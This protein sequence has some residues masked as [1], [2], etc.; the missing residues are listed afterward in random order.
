MKPRS[1]R[2]SNGSEG[3]WF[4]GRFCHRCVKDSEGKP[5]SILGRTFTYNETDK[6]YPKEW[7]EDADGPRCTAF[8][9]HKTPPLSIIRDP[10]QEILI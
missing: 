4:L 6:R 2:P 10:R 8:S 5:C 7:I 1:Y 9:D 3:E